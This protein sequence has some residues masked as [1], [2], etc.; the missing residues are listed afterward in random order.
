M[1]TTT[2]AT[3]TG[4]TGM[5]GTTGATG[6]D[7]PKSRKKDKPPRHPPPETILDNNLN[8]Q[9][10]RGPSLGE[11]GFASCYLIT[12]RDNNR[13]A[14]KVIQK[15]E[16][17]SHKTRQKLFAEIKI[18]Q[19]LKHENIV[20]YHN[21]F[22]DEDFTLMDLIKRRKRLT[23]PEVR[24]YMRELVEGC[25]YLHQ[26]K[27]IHRDLKLGNLFLTHDM[28]VRIGDFGLAAVI[29]NEERKKTICGTPNYIAPEIL[30]DTDNGHSFEVDIW[31]VGVIMY[32]LLVGK[33]PFQTNEVKAIYKKI[34]DNDYV[35]PEDVPIS[36]EAKDL[37]ASLLSPLPSSRPSVGD[38]LSHPFFASGYFPDYLDRTTLHDAP[39]LD[40]EE[41]M[42][43]ES[44]L[45]QQN[46]DNVEPQ[47]S[48]AD[49]VGSQQHPDLFDPPTPPY[50]KY[51]PSSQ[52]TKRYSEEPSE[53]AEMLPLSSPS[54]KRQMQGPNHQTSNTPTRSAA[55][56]Q[57]QSNPIPHAAFQYGEQ[58][59]M[60]LV[61]GGRVTT[62]IRTV[63]MDGGR[64]TSGIQQHHNNRPQQQDQRKQTHQLHQQ[65]QPAATSS[66]NVRDE[67][68]ST[69]DV[70]TAIKTEGSPSR[71]TSVSR[72]T[73]FAQQS[74]SQISTTRSGIV[75]SLSLSPSRSETAS[76]AAVPSP[77][78]ASFSSSSRLPVPKSRL[79]SGSPQNGGQPEA[80]AT[81][82]R[83]SF[84]HNITSP[85]AVTSATLS[86]STAKQKAAS[87]SP[88]SRRQPSEAPSGSELA[89][90][91]SPHRRQEGLPNRAGTAKESYQ[92]IDA[93]FQQM[94]TG[95]IEM[96]G[97]LEMVMDM[98]VDSYPL[99]N[100]DHPTT[101]ST[102]AVH[103][104]DHDGNKGQHHPYKLRSTGS[105]L[106]QP[107]QHQTRSR[108]TLIQT[109]HG[110]ERPASAMQRGY[111]QDGE[112]SDAQQAIVSPRKGTTAAHA[113]LAES[114][115][116]RSSQGS[117]QQ[118]HQRHQHSFLHASQQGAQSSLE[119]NHHP[120]VQIPR[121]PPSP[122]LRLS[123]RKSQ[124]WTADA[125]VST[126]ASQEVLPEHEQEQDLVSPLSQQRH[127]RQHPVGLGLSGPDAEVP[128]GMV[129]SA[130]QGDVSMSDEG[131]SGNDF[132]QQQSLDARAAAQRRSQL[133]QHQQ[134]NNRSSMEDPLRSP[135]ASS[136]QR[137]NQQVKQLQND[138]KQQHQ[139]TPAV[140]SG[141]NNT[142]NPSKQSNETTIGMSTGGHSDEQDQVEVPSTSCVTTTSM[143]LSMHQDPNHQ[144][145]PSTQQQQQQVQDVPAK[146]LSDGTSRRKTKKVTMRDPP[147]DFH[148]RRVGICESVEKY[149]KDTILSRQ[150]GAWITPSMDE[151]APNH[152][153]VFVTRW[154]D[155]ERYGYGWQL[156]N[157]VVGVIYNDRTTLAL[158]PNGVDIEVTESPNKR[159]RRNGASST[160]FLRRRSQ[161]EQQSA[162]PPHR[163]L[164]SGSSRLSPIEPKSTKSMAALRAELRA[165]L[166]FEKK[167]DVDNECQV[168]AIYDDNDQPVG[169]PAPGEE[170]SMTMGS[171][172]KVDGDDDYDAFLSGEFQEQDFYDEWDYEEF[173]ES[174]DRTY[175]RMHSRE[176]PRLAKRIKVLEGFRNYMAH[177]LVSL[178]PWV[179]QDLTLTKGMPFLT[180]MYRRKERKHV[181]VRLSNGIVQ[182]NFADHTKLIFSQNGEIV[183][184]IDND[185][186]SRRL[187][188]TTYQALSPDYFYDPEDELDQRTLVEEELRQIESNLQHH[189]YGSARNGVEENR[190]VF[191]VDQDHD[192]SLF[193]RPHL[194]AKAAKLQQ[195]SS[196]R[197][198]TPHSQDQNEDQNEQQP[199]LVSPVDITDATHV[200]LHDIN[201]EDEPLVILHS[202]L[203]HLHYEFVRRIRLALRLLTARKM[204]NA[205]D[206]M[207]VRLENEQYLKDRDES[208]RRR[209]AKKE[210]EEEEEKARMRSESS[211]GDVDEDDMKAD[212]EDENEDD[213][214]T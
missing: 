6:V 35:F 98:E 211:S 49:Q 4:V 102:N 48:A 72:T 127:H 205:H 185:E 16:L 166:E 30:F 125:F 20:R 140:S 24:Y 76:G 52:T 111:Q 71:R 155:Y 91:S 45:L 116:K 1:A 78:A 142:N 196:P 113:Q 189:R 136:L 123:H 13:Y 90:K 137:R 103:P 175:C 85:K 153:S 23:E 84:G 184:L 51:S 199:R 94:S 202:T 154:I 110:V 122:T 174:L 10:V 134:G 177:W 181:I 93:K 130:V 62:E 32:T 183:T 73:S 28:H 43:K 108:A 161:S 173:L 178:S 21:C 69:Y 18:H 101:S 22:E 200:D 63:N 129:S 29:L 3:A 46:G 39:N 121:A 119:A 107:A 2:A 157:G 182:V 201:K 176:I 104:L 128:G 193:P 143:S 150:E 74:R 167:L 169:P 31:S 146:T 135:L 138:Q 54:A 105:A 144:K 26:Q 86:S 133:H 37:I 209:A 186:F 179:Y 165:G 83:S 204:E 81:P 172:P 212:V 41:R 80:L 97:D 57:Q 65:R 60:E 131:S 210:R 89:V 115:T 117:P 64:A 195:S 100:A 59:K 61:D 82:T 5:T 198:K 114:I 11:G 17:Q 56:K 148:L 207:K 180:D 7:K 42:F 44:L 132:K 160:N 194:R 68:S 12:D 92:S 67:S 53:L 36:E 106:L 124:Q 213:R 171:G 168:M 187:T 112:L 50:P 120:S 66:L 188:M 206:R 15:T 87:P 118:R 8:I 158:S 58:I 126:R 75:Q 159:K 77:A 19:S 99:R 40:T 147:E 9:Y 191:H 33:P 34:R 151:P 149:L 25:A 203:K 38:V 214:E 163:R 162:P 156:S 55:N 70:H 139:L 27:T 96:D 152:P 192:L 145:Q 95:D 88:T 141:M 190:P 109:V 197:Y 79:N 47:E 208:R 14:A 164:E 170:G